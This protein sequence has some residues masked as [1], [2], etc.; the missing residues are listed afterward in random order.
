MWRWV[1]D[2]K[3]KMLIYIRVKQKEAPVL[4]KSPGEACENLVSVTSKERTINADPTCDALRPRVS[5]AMFLAPWRANSGTGERDDAFVRSV[6][7]WLD[8]DAH[9]S[10]QHILPVPKSLIERAR[11]LTDGVEVDLN[12]QLDPD[13]E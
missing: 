13:D 11:E 2:R 12:Q 10:P 7:D 4:M 6:L 3:A 5:D 8:H 1:V 9:A